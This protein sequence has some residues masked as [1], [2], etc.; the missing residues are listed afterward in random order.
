MDMRFGTWNIRS[1][2]MTGAHKAVAEISKCNLDLVGVQEVRWDRDGTKPGGK[3][4]FFCGKGNEIHELGTALFGH[5]RIVSA[6]KR[7]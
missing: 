3:D 1:M 4:T 6:V 7:V 2:Y 5:K